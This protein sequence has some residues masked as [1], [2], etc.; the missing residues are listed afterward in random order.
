MWGRSDSEE[1]DSEVYVVQV[2]LQQQ[3]K[4]WSHLHLVQFVKLHRN[5]CHTGGK[6]VPL[7]TM[8]SDSNDNKHLN[9]IVEQG[10]VVHSL[11]K[12][13]SYN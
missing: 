8:T 12:E 5:H 1:A 10:W 13:F 3:Q 4:S 9:I 11:A 2:F 6:K 7:P